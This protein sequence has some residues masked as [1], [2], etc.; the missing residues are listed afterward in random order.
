MKTVIVGDKGV[1]KRSLINKLLNKRFY[2]V[3]R[4][5]DESHWKST[6]M[7]FTLF[8]QRIEEKEI[9]FQVWILNPRKFVTAYIYGS[10]AGIIVFDISNNDSFDNARKWVETIWKHNGKG[11]IPLVILGNKIDLRH[12]SEDYIS[13]ERGLELALKYNEQT[14]PYGFEVMFREHSIKDE[15]LDL[16]AIFQYLGTCYLKFS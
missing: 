11:K 2:Q 15:K 9:K 10:L 7:A 6:G 5:I 1:G 4:K 12:E 14:I 3:K 13:K 16:G 8:T